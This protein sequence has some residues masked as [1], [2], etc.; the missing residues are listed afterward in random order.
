MDMAKVSPQPKP[1]DQWSKEQLRQRGVH[2]VVEALRLHKE[3]QKLSRRH[4]DYRKV[5]EVLL[6]YL[7]QVQVTNQTLRALLKQQNSPN[8]RTMG[9]GNTWVNNNHSSAPKA[10]RIDD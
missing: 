9:K 8:L 3:H 1:T 2:A 5:T 10:A 7:E 4:A 6:R